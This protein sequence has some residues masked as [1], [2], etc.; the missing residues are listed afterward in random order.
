[1]IFSLQLLLNN[2]RKMSIV[3]ENQNLV[4][5]GKAYQQKIQGIFNFLCGGGV[6]FALIPDRTQNVFDKGNP[7]VTTAHKTYGSVIGG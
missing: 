6:Y 5:K 3:V 4:R 7:W 2:A 1:M